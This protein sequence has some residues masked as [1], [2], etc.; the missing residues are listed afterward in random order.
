MGNQKPPP[1]PPPPGREL[2]QPPITT[3]RPSKP[4]PKPKK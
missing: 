2:G 3:P 4:I 1:P